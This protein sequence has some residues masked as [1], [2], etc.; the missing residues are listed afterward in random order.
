MNCLNPFANRTKLRALP[1]DSAMNLTLNIRRI[2]RV[3]IVDCKG[4]I[5]FG[6]EA[7]LLRQKVKEL[8]P[9]T[10]CIVLNLADV[11]YIDSGGLGTLVS[12]YTSA[13]SAG[14][15]IKLANLTKRVDHLLQITKLITVFATY[16]NA[17]DAAQAFLQPRAS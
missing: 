7:S 11:S 14:S 13:R 10:K 15:D 12:L 8:L 6:E 3:V 2:D 5:T 16:D 4:R 1:E 17:T 9:D